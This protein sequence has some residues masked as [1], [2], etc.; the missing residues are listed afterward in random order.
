[1]VVVVYGHGVDVGKSTGPVPLKEQYR[2]LCGKLSGFP[3]VASRLHPQYVLE[4][5]VAWIPWYVRLSS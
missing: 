3:P 5:F 1:M 4:E 2:H